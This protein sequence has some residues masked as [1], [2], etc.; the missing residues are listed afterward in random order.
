MVDEDFV[1][2]AEAIGVVRDQLRL[3]REAGEDQEP[4]FVV[5]R[6]EVEFAVEARRDGGAEGGVQFGV[7]TLKGRAGVSAGSTHRVRL[8]LTPE[9]DAGGDYRVRDE[10]SGPPDR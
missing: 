7:F 5:G 4:R 3:A 6:V 1:E 10:A 2:L 9:T 8:E